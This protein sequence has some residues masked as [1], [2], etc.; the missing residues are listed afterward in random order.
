MPLTS[1][2]DVLE[3]TSTIA[4]GVASGVGLWFGG[5]GCFTSGG[6]VA[7][8]LSL[9]PPPPDGGG[10]CEAGGC[11][12]GEISSL[13]SLSFASMHLVLDV[14]GIATSPLEPDYCGF[15]IPDHFVVGYGLDFNDEYRHLPFVAVLPEQHAAHGTLPLQG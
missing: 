9:V 8:I 14:H 3:V 2:V 13:A 1:I 12:I 6:A 4:T 15:D 10:L 5:S 7:S 11:G